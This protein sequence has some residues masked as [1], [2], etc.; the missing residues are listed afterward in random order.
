MKFLRQTLES[1]RFAWQALRSNILRTTLSL[2]GVTVGIFAIIGVFTIVDSLE[3]NIRQSLDSIGTDVVYVQK[4]PWNFG[5]EFQ[6]WKYFQ[7]PE[8]SYSDYKF[9][10]ERM[11]GADAVVAM[12]FK[13]GLTAKNGN[14]SMDALVQGVT[15]DYNK[16]ADIDVE[17]G[18]YFMPQEIEAGR[19]VAIVGA[20]IAETL[21]PSDSDPIGK[22]FK[23]KG[24]NYTIIGI[25]KK[26]GKGLFDIAGNPDTKVLM[27]FLTFAK[28]FQNRY[29]SSVSIVAKGK[30]E[31]E[32]LVELEAE[33]TGL[34][35]TKRG[36]KPTQ[37]T[38]FSINRPEAA[39]KAISGLFGVITLAGWVIGSFSILVGGFGIAN[40]MFVSV[41]ERT[42]LIGI[43]K[44]LGAKN[45]F[46][47]FQF[48][49]EAIFLSLIGGLVGI[50]LVYLLSFISLGSL[51]IVLSPQN[52][53][54]GLS[55]SSIIGVIA[56]IVPAFGAA[57]LDPVEAIRSK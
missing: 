8:T 10:A 47:L 57:R 21:F 35:R 13:G 23:V 52:V 56:G 29:E 22:S 49:F 54:L 31:D 15:F 7:W 2:L 4:W 48:L 30:P 6:W 17:K 42:N 12:G 24:L 44:S 27:P 9:L 41:K 33:I 51:D 37:T 3:K 5:G 50:G 39:T 16:V 11:E 53:V 1:L 19:S 38:N 18:R 46:I 28:S 26:K 43:Q 45:Y 25:Q 40:I 20:E 14:N 32:G 36:L 55:V 34:L